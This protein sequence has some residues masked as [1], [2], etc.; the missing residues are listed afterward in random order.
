MAEIEI[1]EGESELKPISLLEF[2]ELLGRVQLYV[3]EDRIDEADDRAMNACSELAAYALEHMV[4]RD[5]DPQSPMWKELS[6]G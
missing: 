1:P 5:F 2:I 6:S 4:E 3:G